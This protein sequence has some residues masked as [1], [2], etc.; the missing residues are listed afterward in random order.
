MKLAKTKKLTV[1]LRNDEVKVCGFLD[2]DNNIW[3]SM[4][5]KYEEAG[6]FFN[7]LNKVIE[8]VK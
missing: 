4:T 3:V 7:R 6:T 1:E 8:A 5:T 2:K